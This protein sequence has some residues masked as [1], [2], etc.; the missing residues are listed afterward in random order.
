MHE[1]PLFLLRSL[2]NHRITTQIDNE[3]Y[4]FCEFANELVPIQVQV[5]S[6]L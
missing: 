4:A 1:T 2:Q 5:L 3:F 6:V